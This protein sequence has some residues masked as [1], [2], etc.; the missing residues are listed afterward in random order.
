MAVIAQAVKSLLTSL[1]GNYGHNDLAEDITEQTTGAKIDEVA[2]RFDLWEKLI[3]VDMKE[4]SCSPFQ[5]TSL[6]CVQRGILVLLSY[7]KMELDGNDAIARKWTQ[8]AVENEWLERN[9]EID[10]PVLFLVRDVVVDIMVIHCVMNHPQR[11][12]GSEAY[13]TLFFARCCKHMAMCIEMYLRESQLEWSFVSSE[14]LA[15]FFHSSYF[16]DQYRDC[17]N[18]QLGLDP[19]S[20]MTDM[21]SNGFSSFCTPDACEDYFPRSFADIFASLELRFDKWKDVSVPSVSEMGPLDQQPKADQDDDED[22]NNKED[23][24]SVT[25]NPAEVIMAKM[26]VYIVTLQ[27]CCEQLATERIS[28]ET[29][30]TM[31]SCL[32]MVVTLL[33]AASSE[34]DDDKRHVDRLIAACPDLLRS[35][36]ASLL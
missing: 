27:H 17:S 7:K 25:D 19:S 30:A 8:L 12:L 10:R 1:I 33:M 14:D 23:G 21:I 9:D 26:E 5:F 35:R 4:T 6:D 18:F 24:E 11:K 36:V 32:K 3:K 2:H 15:Y 22:H 31:S 13:L 34:E 20:K 28:N 16:W 29:W